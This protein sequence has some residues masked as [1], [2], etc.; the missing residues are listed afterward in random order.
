LSPV[1]ASRSH[2]PR[3]VATALGAAALLAVTA[4]GCVSMPNGGPVLP[5]A[6]SPGGSGQAQ[7]YPQIVAPPPIPNA[8]PRDIVRGFLAAGA[9]FVGKQQVAREY[10][11]PQASRA[12]QPGWSAT[13]FSNGPNFLGQ[14]SR[15]AGSSANDKLSGTASASPSPTRSPTATP[16]HPA[17][18]TRVTVTVG[19]SVEAKLLNSGAYAVASATS[20]GGQTYAYDLV[21]YGGQW[22]IARA[23]NTL[24]LTLTEFHADYQLRNL[25]FFDPSSEH[26]VPDPVYVPL[27][28]TQEDLVN[29]LVQD[30]IS[31][32]PDWLA[33]GA[34]QTAFPKGTRLL[35][36]VT[37]DGGIASVNLGGAIAHAQAVVKEQVSAQLLW[38]LRLSGAGQGTQV[39]QAV[40]LSVNGRQFVLPNAQ[41]NPVLGMRSAPS[42]KYKPIDGP[43]GNGF[44]Y[45]DS[46]GALLHKSGSSPQPA[47]VARIGP[48]Y[49]SLAVSPDGQ[50]FAVLRDGVVYTGAMGSGKLSLRDAGGGFSSLSWDDNDN[51]WAAGSVNVVVLPATTKPNTS[52]QVVVDQKGDTCP[53]TTGGVTQLRVAPDAVRVALVIGGQQPMLAFGAIVMQDQ[54]RAGQ[55]QSL[56][57]VNLS[58]FFVC[59]TAGAFRS[60]SW[61]GTDNV[62][63]LGQGGALTE[64]PVNGGTSTTIPGRAGTRSITA[65]WRAGV[66]AGVGDTMFIDPN[67][68]GVWNA[69]GA[70]LSPAYPG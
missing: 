59:G 60:L 48:G 70:G 46:H 9:S 63:A 21:K 18:N 38:T 26:L 58:P 50:Y 66:I 7:P 51:L 35:G 41:G 15:A 55:Q 20:K 13:V 34:T 47:Q 52:V 61:Y 68:T 37:V 29:G 49:S 12:W 16:A 30:L 1:P 40:T 44:Y 4:A 5:Y 22:R 53:G 32:P 65:R 57:H 56:A 6:V 17:A 42:V 69:V 24:L 45:I 10:L 54:P 23:P 33:G 11:T 39:V 64:Y 62:F 67:A 28:A 14:V 27:Q 8:Q 36:K 43:P 25:Y 19:G 2:A 31:Q 3:R